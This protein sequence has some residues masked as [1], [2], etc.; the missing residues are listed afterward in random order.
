MKLRQKNPRWWRCQGMPTAE[1]APRECLA[2]APRLG[3]AAAPRLGLAA[4]PRMGF[5]LVELL[6]VIAII[7]ILIGML[8]PAVQYARAAARRTQCRSNLHNIGLAL[9]MY[10]DT[11]GVYGRYP[12]AAQMKSALV[13]YGPPQS[14]RPTLRVALNPFIET[15]TN[16]FQC[17][18]D[19]FPE[20]TWNDETAALQTQTNDDQTQTFNDTYNNAV[21][22]SDSTFFEAEELSY[23]YNSPLVWDPRQNLPK[24]RVEIVKTRDSGTIWIVFD[25]APFHAAP[26]TVGSRNFLYMDSHVAN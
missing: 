19:V 9:D 25:F 23:E 16:V 8:L 3:L 15:N 24:R 4:A 7:G 26:G 14:L 6:V 13:K 5:T 20:S 1:A 21:N 11:Q 17:P 10:V 12:D 22:P 2:A 18:D